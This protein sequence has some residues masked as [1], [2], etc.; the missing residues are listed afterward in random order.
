MPIPVGAF[1]NDAIVRPRAPGR[2]PGPLTG[3]T[4]NASGTGGYNNATGQDIGGGFNNG[5]GP[6]WQ[7]AF[8]YAAA[9]NDAR[10]RQFVQLLQSF[11]RSQSRLQEMAPQLLAINPD[12]AGN[13]NQMLMDPSRQLREGEQ[14]D[15]RYLRRVTNVTNQWERQLVDT[16]PLRASFGVGNTRGQ[17][18]LEQFM[19]L[20]MPRMFSGAQV[21]GQPTNRDTTGLNPVTVGEN[22]MTAG[23]A[24]GYL[25]EQAA[26]PF[27][28]GIRR[29]TQGGGV[30]DVLRSAIGAVPGLGF[31]AG[32]GANRQAGE[33]T[34]SWDERQALADAGQL[35][36]P[37]EFVFGD[38]TIPFTGRLPGGGGPG[39]GNQWRLSGV[40]DLAFQLAS[41]PLTYTPLVAAKLGNVG[42]RGAYLG[43]RSAVRELMLE[44]V[45]R[46]TWAQRLRSNLRPASQLRATAGEDA[47]FDA[48][49]AGRAAL[50]EQSP[51]V[52][53]FFEGA[54]SFFDDSSNLSQR[55]IRRAFRGMS[56]GTPRSS[57][58]EG[59]VLGAG[60]GTG[61]FRIAR[62]AEAKGQEAALI[63]LREEFILGRYVPKLTLR[64]QLVARLADGTGDG[65]NAATARGIPIF[66]GQ[67]SVKFPSGVRDLIESAAGR[68]SLGTAIFQQGG[69]SPAY[70]LAHATEDALVFGRDVSFPDFYAREIAAEVDGLALHERAFRL[71]DMVESSL[72][73]IDFD[74]ASFFD[75]LSDAEALRLADKLTIKELLADRLVAMDAL[76]VEGNLGEAA[77]R[78]VDRMLRQ[79]EAS[80]A[81]LDGR[82]GGV[83]EQQMRAT[84]RGA[85]K[86]N[87]NGFSPLLRQA[88][89][90]YG[91]STK[92]EIPGVPSVQSLVAE[93]RAVA[94][95]DLAAASWW[96]ANNHITVLPGEETDLHRA[97]GAVARAGK[98]DSEYQSFLDEVDEVFGI[99][100]IEARYS[101]ATR[102]EEFGLARLYAPKSPSELRSI[103]TK[104]TR[105]LPS[106]ASD[107]LRAAVE[108]TDTVLRSLADHKERAGLAAAAAPAP[109]PASTIRNAMRTLNQQLNSR[110]RSI[111]LAQQYGESGE[112]V[113][114]VIREASDDFALARE[115]MLPNFTGGVDYS[116][117]PE[118]PAREYIKQNSPRLERIWNGHNGR[119]PED[120]LTADLGLEGTE[121][122]FADIV[123]IRRKLMAVSQESL[124]ARGAPEQIVVF[125]KPGLSPND[126][127]SVRTALTPEHTLPYVVGR[128]HVLVD[129]SFVR[130]E[131]DELFV[132]ATDLAPISRDQLT[133][134][135]LV[136]A[137]DA[138]L[139]DPNNRTPSWATD[140]SQERGT[141]ALT[142]AAL[143]LDMPE[144]LGSMLKF[145]GR[146]QGLPDI[147]AYMPEADLN[148]FYDEMNN[149]IRLWSNGTD[150]EVAIAYARTH[151]FTREGILARG[152]T[153]AQT[154]EERWNVLVER[155]VANVQADSAIRR[156][157]EKKAR[158]ARELIDEIRT[159]RAT[160]FGQK[161]IDL[162]D[163]TARLTAE[164]EARHPVRLSPEELT[165]KIETRT[166]AIRRSMAFRDVEGVRAELLQAEL[167]AD[168]QLQELRRQLAS[169]PGGWNYDNALQGA[170]LG[171]PQ[172]RALMSDLNEMVNPDQADELFAAISTD[173]EVIRLRRQ[174][175]EYWRQTDV[176]RGQ[177]VYEH[178]DPI[179]TINDPFIDR[180]ASNGD[181]W[182]A[183][184]PF[185]SLD[186]GHGVA[187]ALTEA[188]A[189]PIP[190][191]DIETGL[192][193]EVYLTADPSWL[194]DVVKSLRQSAELWRTADDLDPKLQAQMDEGFEF[195]AYANEG[196]GLDYDEDT[197]ET[198][199]RLDRDGVPENID[200]Y[201]NILSDFAELLRETPP[202]TFTTSP[203]AGS[204]AE[205]AHAE[206][207]F[208]RTSAKIDRQMAA[209][210]R[211][212]SGF[213]KFENN[214]GNFRYL[215]ARAMHLG[216][217]TR[218]KFD[219]ELGG[220]A[221][222]GQDL[223][224]VHRQIEAL[225]RNP[226]LAR[227]TEVLARTELLRIQAQ[228][229]AENMLRTDASRFGLRSI[230]RGPAL[231]LLSIME[232]MTPTHIPF[233]SSVNAFVSMDKR[234]QAGERWLQALGMD[235]PTRTIFENRLAAAKNEYEVVS[236]ID[237]AVAAWAIANDLDADEL[238]RAIR[239]QRGRVA[240]ENAQAFMAENATVK[241]KGI[242][243]GLGR[244]VEADMT[245]NAL[246][247]TQNVN[248]IPLPDP[249]E[250]RIAMARMR[251][252]QE[253]IGFRPSVRRMG[254][255]ARAGLGGAFRAE[256]LGTEQLSAHALIH[257]LHTFWKRAVVTNLPAIGVGAAAGFFSPEGHIEG[258]PDNR[259]QRALIGAGIGALGPVR[260]VMRVVGLDERL[261]YYLTRGLT[262]HEWIP[263]V[264]KIWRRNGTVLPFRTSV[265]EELT[266]AP[267]SHLATEL[268]AESTPRWLALDRKSIRYVDAWWRIVNHQ[269]NPEVDN[270]AG[271]ILAGLSNDAMDD[272]RRLAMEWLTN[273]ADGVDFLKR[274][275]L[276]AEDAVDNYVRFIDNYFTPELAT[277]RLEMASRV[278][279]QITHEALKDF[280][281]RGESP[282]VVHAQETWKV[283]HT[284]RQILETA[285]RLPSRLTLQEPTLRVNRIP[286]AENLYR[287]EM[288]ALI[289]RGVEPE[290]A[291]NMAEEKA[292][293]VVNSVMFNLNNESRFA[294]R[295]DMYAPFQQPREEM[296]RVYGRLVL[297]NPARTLRIGRLAAVGF[298]NG[299][300]SGMFYQDPASGEWVMRVPG[301][302]YLSR[303]FGMGDM[304]RMEL[305]IKDMFFFAQ[306]QS[307]LGDETTNPVLNSALAT[308]PHPGGPFWQAATR[309][310]F[311][312]NPDLHERVQHT[313]VYQFLFPYGNTGYIF[314][315][316]ARRLWYGFMGSPAPWE[317]ASQHEQEQEIRKA[318][319]SV[320]EAL[321]VQAL[322]AWKAENGGAQ[323]TPLEVAA[324]ERSITDD[325][326]FQNTSAYFLMRA[327]IG[328]VAP[329]P[330]RFKFNYRDM[331]EESQARYVDPQTGKL[332]YSEWINDNPQYIPVATSSSEWVGPQ[333]WEH[334][335]AETEYHSD[336]NSN[337]FELHYRET[338]PVSRYRDAIRESIRTTRAWDAYYNALSTPGRLQKEQALMDWR[339]RW[340]DVINPN[341]KYDVTHELARILRTTSPSQRAEAVTAWRVRH[342]IDRGD[343]EEYKAEAQNFTVN[344]WA[345]A[346]DIEDVGRFV[347][348]QVARGADV[349]RL[350]A[351]LEPA[352]QVRYWTWA[353]M[354]LH[355]YPNARWSRTS[356]DEIMASW[357]A[358]GRKVSAVFNDN[359]SLTNWNQFSGEKNVGP[360]M[361]DFVK[362]WRG[363]YYDA[364]N[365]LYERIYGELNPAI[366]A[367]RASGDW[368]TYKALKDQR[369]SLFDMVSAL[370]NK[371]FAE[372]P[373]WNEYR[374]DLM[375][376]L[377]TADM[378]GQGN[379]GRQLM[380]DYAEF[381]VPHIDSN[382]EY[383]Y[384]NMTPEIRRAYVD[385]LTSRLDIPPGEF[386][387]VGPTKIFW[388]YLTDFQQRLLQ[389]NL[390]G[391]GQEALDR[392]KSEDPANSY[393][394]GGNYYRSRG[395][396]RRYGGYGNDGELSWAYAQFKAYN[397]RG[398]MPEPAGYQGY[399]D[400]PNDPAVK[401]KYLKDHPDVANYVSLG[402]MANMPPMYKYMVADIMI[403]NGKWEGD[404]LTVTGMTELAFAQEQFARWNQ[405]NGPKPATYDL[406]VNMPTGEAKARYLRNHPEIQEWIR[407][408]PM[409]NMPEAYRDVV[410]DIMTRYGQWTE[411]NDPLSVALDGF[412]A[413]PSWGREAYLEKHPELS[414][415][416][417]ALRSPKEQ[418]MFNLTTA[419]FA[420]RDPN[421]RR[422]YMSAHPELQQHFIDQRSSRYENFMMQVANFMGANPQM[423]ELY[424]KRQE[425]ILAELFRRFGTSPLVAEL[426]PLQDANTKTGGRGDS[427]RTRKV[428]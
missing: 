286:M 268:L 307:G 393:G 342:N 408:G 29:R 255:K 57:A 111:G 256:R 423:F 106:D 367:A 427:G 25:Q 400:L 382:E 212:Y 129:G 372:Q 312:R 148:A 54:A 295:I 228:G 374:N 9:R 310:A 121:A 337:V 122:T 417:R 95:G 68:R 254:N 319:K 124:V 297:E 355:Y 242:K 293:D 11:K 321:Y 145:I 182:L 40:G 63:A 4:W 311:N 346:R 59:G 349:D 248:N 217:A 244:Q 363:D 222:T 169:V 232:N 70:V 16:S 229:M 274:L 167:S 211:E 366:D 192:I 332:N 86:V 208:Q 196:G 89:M 320:Y 119:D 41:D 45:D 325:D 331:I 92:A 415:Y 344:P 33:D 414:E 318:E 413:T 376:Y 172:V 263:V 392:W 405:R 152:D 69:A 322:E 296:L 101:M 395:G 7:N 299:Q 252:G 323:P 51:V 88:G 60:E 401:A 14:V 411:D 38:N 197:S 387:D 147:L 184:E 213:V 81:V 216:P 364:T 241:R 399:L 240:S 1:G 62:I 103:A 52:R 34:N 407:N 391:I 385:R 370:K 53:Q 99:P 308:V 301:S 209:L 359:P 138:W 153:A 210:E 73:D 375:S 246:L 250:M 353:K 383:Q 108:A 163:L 191:I 288:Q 360:T 245:E 37:G 203:P 159:V 402:P 290:L 179:E 31:T 183:S 262:P 36:S 3:I 239:D 317:F 223:A 313:G 330:T 281:R 139:L 178:I 221:R 361:E 235:G 403:R 137:T 142:L 368:T 15:P 105:S 72:A 354:R 304:G 46:L 264:S 125:V 420:L 180:L 389:N 204:V 425:D 79:L 329:A 17:S 166:E 109:K 76:I 130:G 324:I 260:Y 123:A 187:G 339:R 56:S 275:G 302:A 12:L 43:A 5:S 171:H 115:E 384:H 50:I 194:D 8:R 117:M 214:D 22:L 300:D 90:R 333:D 272:A 207:L 170:V 42:E 84:L 258:V 113:R 282:D 10:N 426:G 100:V 218:A 64:R 176:M 94:A 386:P 219:A 377:V 44:E 328:S 236:L 238:L 85:L 18:G 32:D 347:D 195:S 233:D 157:G 362:E 177:R 21:P 151:G 249:I 270:L 164:F 185:Y 201:A 396:Y 265:L 65:F 247:V 343:Y 369:T 273:N 154:A 225:I 278:D 198:I 243:G 140:L 289:G 120:W 47:L 126:V 230:V 340:G 150:E 186:G 55:G 259:F 104:L 28:A 394:G 277:L 345:E 380:Y 162:T 315:P 30:G 373:D 287:D 253:A 144:R 91:W 160:E 419:Y 291:R 316:E 27:Y 227:E 110:I 305:T 193:D 351:T 409:A 146:D 226:A 326:V 93:Q 156:W 215:R 87:E 303:L 410:R 269:V 161:K 284:P 35:P 292:L 251:G 334:W 61:A 134:E 107:E 388:S 168:P 237:S 114:G 58:V 128:D 23:N 306:G 338:I 133:V 280:M 71:A 224:T 220:L 112:F 48:Q 39:G 20:A 141:H 279:G 189:G 348:G 118:G 158:S 143:N 199:L 74:N 136:A 266:S 132:R 416:W 149:A 174:V 82:A 49:R 404:V 231:V 2:A 285:H 412:Y 175:M 200:G 365:A 379:T 173:P 421:A 283:P 6:E 202:G 406:W 381:G 75:N 357:Y 190:F 97:V 276:N 80:L 418:H 424:L 155:Y 135:E 234:L 422:L 26:Q 327:S 314:R 298:Q 428:S 356:P 205:E 206:W 127:T 309:L 181:R 78:E 371:Q 19:S 398:N 13:L 24:L 378:A 336:S 257:R 390:A 397:R 267:L 341:N 188:G 83:A 165:A 98:F 116:D 96:E 66:L 102:Q 352:E 67:K 294:D 77:E 261:R 131:H 271:I 358:L 335:D 350:V